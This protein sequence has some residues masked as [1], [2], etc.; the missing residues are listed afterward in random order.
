MRPRKN[1]IKFIVLLTLAA[2]G[3]SG[4]ANKFKKVSITSAALESVFPDGLRSFNA[5]VSIGINNPA[6]TF[7]ILH[8]HADVFRDSAAVLHADAENIAVDGRSERTYR[9]PVKGSFDPGL[10]LLQLAIMAKNFKPEE[11]TVSISARA[12][13]AGIG[14]DLAYEGIPLASLLKKEQE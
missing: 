2:A 13:V 3:V 14:K 10:P 8:L 6:P 5:V 9:I 7:D 12:R 4:C 11:Y 1:A